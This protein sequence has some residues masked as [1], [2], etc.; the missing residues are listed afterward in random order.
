[1]MEKNYSYMVFASY[2]TVYTHSYSIIVGET[3]VETHLIFIATI[4]P[5]QGA[6]YA[7]CVR[8][9]CVLNGHCTAHTQAKYCATAIEVR[10]A[11]I[12]SEFQVKIF[13]ICGYHI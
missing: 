5:V 9:E 1:M 4:E 12:M 8:F 13:W 6:L 2:I 10:A 11:A 7:V 3:Q